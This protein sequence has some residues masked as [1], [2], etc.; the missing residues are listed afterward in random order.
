LCYRKDQP[1]SEVW[2]SVR[3][4]AQ[5]DFLIELF[6]SKVLEV[7]DV[8]RAQKRKWLEVELGM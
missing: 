4:Q 8:S 7:A 3:N 6:G 5:R 2:S 1:L